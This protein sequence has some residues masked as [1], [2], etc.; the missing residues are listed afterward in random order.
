VFTTQVLLTTFFALAASA[1]IPLT[2]LWLAFTCR[3][4]REANRL[5]SDRKLDVRLHD[6][7]S[8]TV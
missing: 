1:A 7:T 2:L 3:E 5:A 4:I 8:R 6:D